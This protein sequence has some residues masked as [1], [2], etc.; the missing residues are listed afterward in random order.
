VAGQKEEGYKLPS[1][2]EYVGYADKELRK[3]LMANAKASFV[4]SQYIEP[5][6]G[7]Q[8]ENLFCGTPTIT[9]DWGAFVENNVNGLTGYRCRTF[10]D[11]VNAALNIDRIKPEDCRKFAQQFTLVNVAPRYERYFN[12]VLNVY[13]CGG[14]YQIGKPGD[15]CREEMQQ[16]KNSP[17]S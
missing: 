4:A 1:H 17:P 16:V 7:V 10:E 8:V 12:D 3:Q 6:G 13:T 9:T 14:W 2:V 5:F 11:F 15:Q